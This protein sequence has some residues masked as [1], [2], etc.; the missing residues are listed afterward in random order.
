M[1]KGFVLKKI[2]V[3]V[4]ILALPGFLYY[5]LTAKGKNRYKPL[6]FY[7][8][9]QVAKTGHKVRGT[10]IPDT[11]YHKISDFN[12]KDQNGES[13]S[14]K[15]FDK[16]IFVANF[17]YTNCPS[18]C[19]TVNKNV[20]ELVYA[21]RKNP[22]VYFTSITVDPIRDTPPVLKRYSLKYQANKKWLFLSGDTSTTYNLARNGFLVNAVQVAHNDFIYSD[23]LILIDAEKRIRGYYSGTS[24]ADLAKLNDEIKVLISE[25]LR[26][27]DKALY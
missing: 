7:G 11:I 19:N 27:V 5:L 26:K 23:K 10:F 20:S 22:M 9:K 2:I 13:V 17:F 6:S 8:P 25:E 24:S 14:F 15:S 4:L 18:I 3:L 16:K 1:R 21:Y 12:L